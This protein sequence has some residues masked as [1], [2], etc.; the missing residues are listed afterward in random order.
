[1][2]R[3]AEAL[4]P[5]L[6]R[7]HDPGEPPVLLLVGAVDHEGR[8][9]QVLPEDADPLRRAGQQVLLLEDGLLHDARA[10]SPVL[11]RP[12]HRAVSRATELA[13]PLAMRLEPLSRARRRERLRRV[14]REPRPN[15]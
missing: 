9:H 3:L 11:D 7:G 14:R 15:L 2:L 1:G 6:A 5:D 4:R 12:P 8:S 13:L 10:A